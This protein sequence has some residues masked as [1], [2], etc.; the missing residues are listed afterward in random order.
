[1]LKRVGVEPSGDPFNSLIQLE[2]ENGI[3]RNP[4]IN[5]GAIVVADILYSELDNPKV[6]FIDFVRSISGDQSINYNE[7]VARSE[8]RTGTRNAALAYFL[9]SAKNLKNDVPEVLDLYFHICSIEMNCK[10]LANTFT[11]YANHGLSLIHI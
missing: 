4:F 1:M 3:P 5:S 10:Q 6:D 2:H 8:Y 7:K 11:L 9:K